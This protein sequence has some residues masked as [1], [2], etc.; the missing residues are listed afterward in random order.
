L[1]GVVSSG[2]ECFRCQSADVYE[3]VVRVVAE[4]V[5]RVGEDHAEHIRHRAAHRFAAAI[6][7]GVVLGS[8]ATDE[9]SE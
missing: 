6:R 7:E 8:W 3:A 4:A 5:E 2:C 9:V 1:E